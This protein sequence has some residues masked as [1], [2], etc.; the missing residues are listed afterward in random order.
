MATY[1]LSLLTNRQ[2]IISLNSPCYF[3]KLFSPNKVNWLLSD[4]N[5][6]DK[7]STI[8]SCSYLKQEVCAKEIPNI[9]NIESDVIY[10]CPTDE[11]L[12]NKYIANEINLKKEILS[13]GLVSRTEDFV[14][15]NLFYK[16]YHDLFKL[17]P[18]LEEKYNLIKQKAYLDENTQIYCAQIRIGGKRPNVKNDRQFNH[19][20]ISKKFWK[21]VRKNFI[22]NSTNHNWKLFVTSD[23]ESVEMEAVDEFGK[24][25]V[26]RI[27]GTSS[28]IGMEKYSANNCS[29]IEKPIL[30]FHFL[31]NCDKAVIS[32]SGFGRLGMNNR[33][34]PDKDLY[35]LGSNL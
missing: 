2:F 30:D 11:K 33:K 31:Q 8:L 29:R 6:T 26:I 1:A 23:I 21:F 4:Y 22:Q 15:K 28:H 17:E 13:L 12:L 16:W 32:L 24:E 7:T 14:L 10:M 3:H 18:S 35:R 9:K 34:Q 25:K 27:L 20:N 5:L 19:R